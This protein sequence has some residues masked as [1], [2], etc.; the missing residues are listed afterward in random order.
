M[1]SIFAENEIT[2]TG[3]ELS[4]HWIYRT[5]GIKGSAIAAFIGPVRVNL[6]E[7]VDIE[8]VINNEPISSDKMLNFI[9]EDFDIGLGQMISNQRLFI[10]IVKEVLEEYGLHPERRGDDIYLDVS[11]GAADNKIDGDKKGKLSVSIATKSLTSS[12]I[13]TALNIV[14]SGAPVTVSSLNGA[15]IYDIREFGDK[16]LKKFTDEIEDMAFAK[17]KVRGVN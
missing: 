13:H 8:D 7:M 16:I 3:A 6:S 10:C 11:G 12:L 2:Y 1:K 17:A 5:F 15:G 14:S 9:I 4:P